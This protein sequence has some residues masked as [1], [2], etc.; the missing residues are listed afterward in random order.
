MLTPEQK[1]R[2]RKIIEDELL[3]PVQRETLDSIRAERRARELR[4][5]QLANQHWPYGHRHYDDDRID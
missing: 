2:N 1:E 4:R 5:K 3:H